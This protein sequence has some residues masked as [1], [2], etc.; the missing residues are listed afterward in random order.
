MTVLLI[1]LVALLWALAALLWL[2]DG[3]DSTRLAVNTALAP[4][5]GQSWATTPEDDR[6]A[7]A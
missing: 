2:A 6:I 4:E 5:P 7:A 3:R 1:A